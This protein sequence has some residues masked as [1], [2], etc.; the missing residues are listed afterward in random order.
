MEELHT[1]TQRMQWTLQ[2][3]GGA[4][5]VTSVTTMVSFLATAQSSFPGISTFGSFASTL[6]FANFCAVVIFFPTV[7]SVAD[8]YFPGRCCC[9]PCLG[10]G[11]SKA[12]GASVAPATSAAD[13]KGA[14]APARQTPPK[15]GRLQLYF[16][17]THPR[18]VNAH[19][20]KIIVAFLALMAAVGYIASQL[21]VDPEPPQMFP[22]GNNFAEYSPAEKVHFGQGL[23]TNQHRIKVEVVHGFALADG[24]NPIDR[25]GTDP[26]IKED[27]GVPNF[28]EEL[29]FHQLAPCVQAICARFKASVNDTLGLL[30]GDESIVTCWTTELFEGFYEPMYG[31]NASAQWALD[32]AP[33]AEAELAFDTK[34]QA[35]LSSPAASPDMRRDVVYGLVGDARVPRLSVV[36][37]E[38]S[39]ERNMA[40]SDGIDYVE[41]WNATVLS[42]VTDE[43][44]EC[45]ALQMTTPGAMA[46]PRTG[47]RFYVSKTLIREAFTGILFSLGF[48]LVILTIFSGNVI[49]AATAIIIIASVVCV[50]VA[51]I[52]LSGAKLGMLQSLL[53]VMVPGLAVDS[54]AHLCEAYIAESHGSTGAEDRYARMTGALAHVGISVLSGAVTTMGASFVLQVGPTIRF[55]TLF[56]TS[57]FLVV[58][59]GAL[60][61]LFCFSALMYEFGPQKE[62]GN[63]PNPFRSSKS[64]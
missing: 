54:T 58:T 44:A 56:G 18:F 22:A 1:K 32:I 14:S 47:E 33:G 15:R 61:S 12:S 63:I 49:V 2:R 51:N 53:L 9:C 30:G 21:E 17:D 19:R 59:V 60:F 4:M 26:A 55:F 50:V 36:R 5:L 31:L 27:V 13:G 24:A 39:K 57:I 6:V 64:T 34:L 38:T 43:I 28:A 3:A 29:S 46:M 41:T 8:A 40:Y 16:E 62:F 7:V 25:T 20:R 23:G 42:W 45:A 37:V 35:Y 48:A 11:G 10:G 52:V